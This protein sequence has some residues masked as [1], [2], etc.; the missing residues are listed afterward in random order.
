MKFTNEEI[1]TAINA[2][3]IA[4]GC[5]EKDTYNTME[6]INTTEIKD[7]VLLDVSFDGE[8]TS[9]IVYD[10][11]NGTRLCDVVWVM[12]DMQAG[13]ITSEEIEDTNWQHLAD[14]LDGEKFAK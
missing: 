5:E 10:E 3:C 9:I 8:P 11:C 6:I 2:Y 12:S 7:G 1:L 13:T 4:N 14:H